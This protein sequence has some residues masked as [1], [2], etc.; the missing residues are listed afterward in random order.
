MLKISGLYV[1]KLQFDRA[2]IAANKKA[3]KVA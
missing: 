2:E 3:T 1:A